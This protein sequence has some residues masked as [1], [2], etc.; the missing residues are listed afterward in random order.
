MFF[1]LKIALHSLASHKLRTALA[2]LGVFLGALALTGVQHVS[3][4]MLKK[5]QMEV[6]KFGPNLLV[7]IA[8]DIRFRRGS[9]RIAGGHRTFKISDAEALIY[10]LPFVLDG[11]PFTHAQLPVRYGATKI[12]SNVVATW[13]GFTRVRNFSPQYGRFFTAEENE[14]RAMVVVLGRK[15][16]ERLFGSAR[17]ALGKRV[18]VYR[19]G[20]KVIGVMEPKGRD[21][22]GDDQ[23][24]QVF[25]PL[26]TYMRRASNT[27]WISGA[28]LQMG[29]GTTTEY[30][31]ESAA[32][33][34]RKRHGIRPGE[35]DDFSVFTA[36][37]LAKMQEQAL[38]LVSTLGLI[39]SSVSFAVGGLGIL[40]IMVLLV[41][42]RRIEIGVRRALGA[43]RRHIINQF[44]LE[45]GLMS[46]AG[47]AAGVVVSVGLMAVVAVAASFPFVFDPVLVVGALAGS[48]F[49]GVAAGAYPAWQAAQVAILDV[50]RSKE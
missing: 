23:D 9:V 17:A 13:P 29:P 15:I 24:E 47:G 43:K 6:D 42:A 39:S 44:L 27:H 26:N 7:A 19:A 2:M 8:S 18:Y 30:A 10:S 16:A 4:A 12:P 3:Q 11:V 20:L 45:A 35:D 49:I 1:S 38:E 32:S 48:A 46:A 50:L 28:F 33:L 22:S 21:P 37:E 5:T 14:D 40:S 36:R 25:L 31:K 34:L 41:R